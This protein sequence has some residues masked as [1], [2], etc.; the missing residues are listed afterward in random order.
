MPK[1]PERG[2]WEDHPHL[3]LP[4]A[5][6]LLAARERLQP[7]AP[8]LAQAPENASPGQMGEEAMQHDAIRR[9]AGAGAASDAALAQLK[10]KVE[11]RAKQHAANKD[12]G[13]PSKRRGL[14]KRTEAAQRDGGRP[15]QSP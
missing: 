10:R 2:L 12:V 11:E 8:A 3:C 15:A 1:R 14:G 9:D 5:R 7:A 4:L 6:R 13:I